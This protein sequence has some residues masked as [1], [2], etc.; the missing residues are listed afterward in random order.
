MAIDERERWRLLDDLERGS[1]VDEGRSNRPGIL[2]EA[3]NAVRVMAG[4]V[5]ANE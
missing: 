4:E 2:R 3:D 5:G 1:R